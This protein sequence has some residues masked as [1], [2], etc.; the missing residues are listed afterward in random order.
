LYKN[1]RRN[2]FNKKLKKSIVIVCLF[3]TIFLINTIRVNHSKITNNIDGNFNKYDQNLKEANGGAILFQ[4]T[5]KPL[6]ITDFGNLYDN[7]QHISLTNQEEFNLSYFLDST[8]NWSASKIETK[9]SSIQDTR[10]WINNSEFK[11]IT[12]YRVY[13]EFIQDSY[14]KGKAPGWET[15]IITK[16]GA[17]YMRAHFVNTSFERYYDFL[18]I[19]NKSMGEEYLILDG[20][21]EDFY[22]PWIPG[23][24]IVVTYES[25]GDI[26]WDGYYIDYYEFVNTSSNYDIN[27]DSWD[28][29]YINITNSK[30][31]YGSGRIGNSDGMWVSLYSEKKSSWEFDYEQGAF[32]ELYQNL[33]IPRGNVINAYISFDYYVQNGLDTNENYIYFQINKHKIY[34]IGMRD[35]IEAG[36][37][38]WYSTGK[39]YKDLWLNNSKIFESTIMNQELNVSVGIMIGDSVSYS[40]FQ[41]AFQNIVW[42]DNI[43]LVLTTIAN[44]SQMDIN[45]EFNGL[46]LI[47]GNEWGNA[48][49]NLTGTW[50]QNPIIVNVN[51][52]S[53]LLKFDLDTIIY[54]FHN[55]TSK[56]NQQNDNGIQYTILKNGTIYWEFYHNLYI[57]PS[58]SDNE[59]KIKKPKEW[60]FLYVKDSTLQIIPFTKG[61]SGDSFLII[62]K[63][64]AN[65]PG[66]WFFKARSPNYLNISN[67]K[68]F[69]Q[70]DW[71]NNAS[72]NVEDFTQ[73]KTELNSS[74]VIPKDTAQI[75]L[76][77]YHPN[78]SLFY[79]ENQTPINGNVTF[80]AIT[81]GPLNTSGGLYRYTLFWSNGTSLGGL[82]SNFLVVHQS[83]ITLIKPDDAVLDLITEAFVGD[84]IPLRIQLKDYENNKPISGAVVTYNWST[85][86]RF[87]TEAALGVYETIL[88]TSELGS[89]GFYKIFI[90]ASKLGFE[91]Y[92]LTL[93]INLFEETNLLRLDSEYY[94]ELHDNSTIKY[95]YTNSTGD[96]ILGAL[97]NVNIDSAYYHVIDHSDGNYS[98]E[99]DTSYINNLGIYQIKLNFS[100]P[101]FETQNAIFQFEII[102]QSVD[103]IVYIKS[104][105]VQENSL[106]EA[107]FKE[108]LNVSIRIFAKIDEIYLTGGNITWNSESYNKKIT[109]DTDEWFN[110]T[111]PLSSNNFSAGLNY[112]YITFEQENYKI[113]NFGFQ[114]LISAQ[115]VNIT[116]LINGREIPEH[117]IQELTFK[118]E[119][120]I[121]VKVFAMGE[122]IYLYNANITFISQNYQKELIETIY[123]WYNT[124]IIISGSYFT[125]GVNYIY[126]K[127][128]LENF[129]TDTF[130]FQFLI[131]E[132]TVNISTYINNQ[133]IVENS[134]QELVFKELI[135]LSVKIFANGEKIYLSSANITFISDNYNKHI[136][137][138]TF[139]WYNTSIVISNSYFNSG[140]NYV[141]LLFQLE[142]Y[143]TD[144]FSFQLLIKAQQIN[145]SVS[146]NSEEIPENYLLEF[147]FNEEFSISAQVYAMAEKCYLTGGLMTFVV[148]SYEKDCII[149]DNF[150]YTTEIS[151]SPDFFSL[152]VNY[153]YLK[154]QKENYSTTIFSFQIMINQIEIQM[155]PLGFTDTINAL[156]GE[157]INIRI[158]LIDPTNNNSIENASVSF[159]WIG[160]IGMLNE[161]SPGEYQFILDLPK[162]LKG[163]Y[164]FNLIIAPKESIY[165]STQQT[166]L[167]II[168]EP[169]KNNNNSTLLIWIII[170][171]ATIIIGI[172]GALSLRSYIL[173]PRRRKKEAELLAK[174]QEFKD[175]SNIQ[176]IVIIHTLSGIPL[177]SKS[178]SIL[179][180]H[181]K[182]LFSGFIQ[183]IT[184]IGEEFSEVETKQTTEKESAKTHRTEK[185]IELNFKYFYCLIGDKGDVRVVLILKEKASE[186][187]KSQVSH[188]LMSLNMKLSKELDNWDGA[189][190]N[191]E[192]L[193]PSIINDYF[194]LSYKESFKLSKNI[195]FIKLKKEKFLSKMELRV[196][197]VIESMAKDNNKIE[198]LNSIIE[199]VSEENK[200]LIIEAVESLIKQKIIMPI[201]Q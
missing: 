82:E 179:E 177:Y 183:A 88:D 156:V 162:S 180:K 143:T 125:P 5:E 184:M 142:N 174:T 104:Q 27:F 24:E 91:K 128:Q 129:T 111:I 31:D 138:V 77:V 28:F 147:D 127:F 12:I 22:S 90:N 98:I 132:Q 164:R 192:I 65:F 194:K 157:T 52:T 36:K 199:V 102:E 57:P 134:I 187:L 195:N 114:L 59:F 72:F 122:M 81:F 120:N 29:N 189:L 151:C 152:G 16:L 115:S 71:V 89:N 83:S 60:D 30:N 191:L 7:N 58:Y 190:D 135:N 44:S 78:G 35:V 45:L 105:Q 145:V 182:E 75:F 3:F 109:E 66:W 69:K 63:T 130:S 50:Q 6:N 49:L 170:G 173:I 172:L 153:A 139:P 1:K 117:S 85:G 47:D 158:K 149:Y 188:L 159:T 84:I 68:I 70:G 54:G 86:L 167:I 67:T 76:T 14:T 74:N 20:I 23:D 19:F 56:I 197:N 9:V 119:I 141:Y 95:S 148:N 106:V 181:K 32:S 46:P 100:A 15:S 8:H 154:F 11:N 136:P 126:I 33:T 178:Y 96:G 94:I 108:S 38:K 123:P 175:L 200:N 41:D 17:K 42:F 62:N 198:N 169:K 146:I 137:E 40:Y 37:D 2:S 196:I 163:N 43:T 144:T 113:K 110:D 64:Y 168:T 193:I 39:I 21:R 124:S 186:R 97:I 26:Q 185:I 101:A 133:Q 87:F 51:T 201:N 107:M 140:I 48:K 4:G 34:S 161:S 155:I 160:E 93:K 61:R 73:I 92:N 10:N 18:Y 103:V 55:T 99:F 79:E 13:Q 150:W 166:F 25:D 53:P 112:V 121:S 118:E 131:S 116:T 171:V 80:S 165:R 176:A